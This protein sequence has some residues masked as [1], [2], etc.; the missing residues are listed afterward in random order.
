MNLRIFSGCFGSGELGGDVREW[1]DFFSICCSSM[2]MQFRIRASQQ[3]HSR[4]KTFNFSPL[5]NVEELK[6]FFRASEHTMTKA[7]SPEEELLWKIKRRKHFRLASKSLNKKN[8]RHNLNESSS[9]DKDD[10]WSFHHLSYVI[11]Y[12]LSN[13]V[14]FVCPF[15]S[16]SFNCDLNRSKASRDE[17]T[18]RVMMLEIKIPSQ[19]S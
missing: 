3:Q 1:K 18:R 4:W 8:H 17:T 15:L 14:F 10:K 2:F 11:Q 19:I 13:S 5:H 16:K 7:T 12:E 6:S 9:D